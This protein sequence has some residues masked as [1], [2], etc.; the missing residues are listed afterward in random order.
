[1]R[2]DGNGFFLLRTKLL[3][4]MTASLLM[5]LG[6]SMYRI[7]A[8]D[9]S[10]D[11]YPPK[12]SVEEVVYLPTVSRP[13]EVI[14]SVSIDVERFR[15]MEEVIDKM[16]YEAAVIGGDAITDVRADVHENTS[17]LFKNAYIRK[18]YFSKVIVFK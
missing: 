17:E 7:D 3:L 18:R 16:K 8:K 15:T 4:L 12:K 10:Y 11:Y 6:C 13:F 1:M 14:G 5:S 9:I 2:K